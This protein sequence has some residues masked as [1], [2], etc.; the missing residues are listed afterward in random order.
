MSAADPEPARPEP[1]RPSFQYSLQTL[2]L[3]FVVL[4][5]SLAVF[6]GWGI[7]VFAIVIGLAIYVRQR[8]SLAWLALVLL[9]LSCLAALLMPAVQSF[10]TLSRRGACRNNLREIALALLN[11][12][13][14]NGCFP[15]A[16]IADKNGRPMHSWRVLILPYLDQN[17]LY[18]SYDF[19]EAWDGV[20]NKKLLAACPTVY[21]CPNANNAYPPGA[22][23]TGFVAVVGPNAAWAGARPRRLLD[24]AGATNNTVMLIEADN[25]GIQWT[26]PRDLSL[27]TLGSG[28][29][30]SPALDLSRNHYRRE[31]FFCSYDQLCGAYVAMAD[32]SVHYLPP[33]N[34]STE[35][36]R[37][38][39]QVAAYPVKD[40]YYPD[41]VYDERLRLN[42]PNIAALAVW[43]LSVGALLYRAVRSRRA[44]LPLA[45]ARKITWEEIM[46]KWS[47]M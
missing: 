15:P 22:N 28:D 34:L 20:R 6:G 23:Q 42:W 45:A 7:V 4:A 29:A 46:S 19:N 38:I 17:D 2:L 8:W 9:C 44:R 11:Y 10:P 3:L 12:E 33:G 16:Y 25:S 35:H 43:L 5:S 21:Q 31:E 24:F 36:L 30:R 37:K 47:G 27:D 18:K 26:E 32:G 13:S 40:A 1:K 41:V 39:L 14:V